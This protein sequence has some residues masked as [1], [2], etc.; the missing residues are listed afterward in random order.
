MSTV[1]FATKVADTKTA[2][3][4]E[5]CRA[6]WAVH[7]RQEME[8]LKQEQQQLIQ[9]AQRLGTDAMRYRD[10]ILVSE[11]QLADLRDRH[12]E[13]FDSTLDDMHTKIMHSYHMETHRHDIV[14]NARAC[15]IKYRTCLKERET[16]LVEYQNWDQGIKACQNQLE[17]MV[18]DQTVFLSHLAALQDIK[19][20]T[21][22]F[23]DLLQ[24]HTTD[25]FPKRVLAKMRLD[26][27]CVP[28]L[29]VD[30]RINEELDFIETR[31]TSIRVREIA[32]DILDNYRRFH[33]TKRDME[34]IRLKYILRSN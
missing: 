34:A 29:L 23:R 7:I 3:I 32:R 31:Y 19:N 1:I 10:L 20:Q 12:G 5:E 14:I 33:A 9:Q 28:S 16:L 6:T 2:Q 11:C 22:H 4:F 21:C 17:D 30:K 27:Y 25:C 8:R 26:P 15:L 13:L 18:A 24:V